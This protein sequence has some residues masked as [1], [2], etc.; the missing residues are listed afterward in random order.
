MIPRFAV[1]G[2]PNKGKSSIVSTLA[3]D[4]KVAV[5]P[6]PGTTTKARKFAFRIDG[7][8]IYELI[9]TPGF[10][11]P[12]AVLSWL[13]SNNKSAS[14]RAKSVKQFVD[15]HR[16]DAR[17]HDEVE[18]LSPLLDGA[19]ILYVVDGSKPF[20]PEYETEMEILRWTGR[21]RM[22]LI[23]MI[24]DADYVADWRRALDQYFSLVRVFDALHADRSKRLSLLRSFREIHEPW[25]PAIESAMETLENAYQ[26]RRQRA[27][28]I[29]AKLLHFSLTEK[30]Q[31]RLKTQVI[32]DEQRNSLEEELRESLRRKEQA[33]HRELVSLYRHSDAEVG[34][35]NLDSLAADIF[36]KQAETLFGLSKTQLLASG[37]LSGGVAGTGIDILVGGTSLMTGAAIGAVVGG[38]SAVLGGGRLAK[39]KVLGQ[40]LGEH[41]LTVGPFKNVNLPWILLGRALLVLRVL[42]ERNHARR[43]AIIVDA[44]TSAAAMSQLD[45]ALRRDLDKYFARLRADASKADEQTLVKKLTGILSHL[46]ENSLEKG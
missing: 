14:E 19:A 26:H 46:D 10:Q 35:L 31:R 15:L 8:T 17:F 44:S 36:S 1:V 29:I 45:S 40:T 39:A 22:A 30:R 42:E 23:N 13:T 9:D 11:R 27:L 20:G 34:G 2:H 41:L 7:Q 16:D 12:G 38:A 24:G 4:A 28:A 18:L 33:A 6:T 37:A 21:P 43:D 3:E 5:A 25:R 32:A